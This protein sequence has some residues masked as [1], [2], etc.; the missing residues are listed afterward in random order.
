MNP[1]RLDYLLRLVAKD[2]YL[3][4]IYSYGAET[5]SKINQFFLENEIY[6]KNSIIGKTVYNYNKSTGFN[7]QL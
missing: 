1:K 6:E 3:Q 5:L 7:V 2:N 4:I